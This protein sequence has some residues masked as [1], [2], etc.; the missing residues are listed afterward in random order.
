MEGQDDALMV[1]LRAAESDPLAHLHA[2]VPLL[3]AD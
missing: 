1:Q 3:Y 2:E